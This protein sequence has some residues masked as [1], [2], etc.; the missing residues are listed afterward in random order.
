M[1]YQR[2]GASTRSAN[3]IFARTHL[4]KLLHI[5]RL[6][7]KPTLD[8]RIPQHF[9]QRKKYFFQHFIVV[10]ILRTINDLI[11]IWRRAFII[12][13]ILVVSIVLFFIYFIWKT[14]FFSEELFISD[15]LSSNRTRSVNLSKPIPR[16]MFRMRT[17]SCFMSQIDDRRFIQFP[18]SF[19]TTNV[20]STQNFV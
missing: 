11:F 19:V 10:C 9:I 5:S 1:L 12:I 8:R 13:L 15:F 18:S 2:S 7:Q 6:L 4:Q 17:C 16:K 3:L 20:T 14:V